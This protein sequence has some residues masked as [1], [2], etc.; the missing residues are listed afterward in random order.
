MVHL[1]QSRLLITGGAG[2]IG[3]NL[4]DYFLK[5][6]NNVV[7]LD[8]LSTGKYKNIAPFVNNKRFKFIEGDIRD[9]SSCNEAVKGCD[10]VFHQAALGSVP[11]S[12]RDP[13][14]TNDVN[15]NGFLK[16][17]TA[18]KNCNVKRFIYAAS[19]STYGDSIELPK[20][21]HNIGSPLSPY[22]V[23]KLVNELYAQVYNKIYGMEIIGLRYFN[24]FGKNQNPDSSYSAVIP[25]WIKKFINLERPVI[26]GDGN[27]SRD[28]T[29]IDNVIHANEIAALVTS[30][31]YNQRA[32]S[33]YDSIKDKPPFEIGVDNKIIDVFNVAHG[34]R[35]TLFEL[36]NF[37]REILSNHKRE[38]LNIQPIIGEQRKGDIPHSQASIKKIQKVLGYKK[39]YDLKEGL[40]LAC[41]WYLQSL[42]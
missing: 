2:F 35:T 13:I 37:I 41:D 12:I 38:I 26:N 39:K 42:R 33:Y 11:R 8:N 9:E 4:V 10:F 28:F 36:F 22:A 20:I 19:S 1:K 3:S 14:A 5:K 34:S 21:E 17:L 32:E 15:I 7:C 31:D 40:K 25:I 24:V 27:Y 23:T 16:M 6:D 18:A 30:G 29:Y